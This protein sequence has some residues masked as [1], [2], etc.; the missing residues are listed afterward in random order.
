MHGITDL[1]WWTV[2]PRSFSENTIIQLILRIFVSSTIAQ[3]GLLVL[4]QMNL[5]LFLS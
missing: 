2:T 3:H 1:C 4:A 5:I